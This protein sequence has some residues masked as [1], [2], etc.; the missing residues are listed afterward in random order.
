M[1]AMN[2]PFIQLLKL[3]YSQIHQVEKQE[4]QAHPFNSTVYY[5]FAPYLLYVKGYSC[6]EM[7]QCCNEANNSLKFSFGLHCKNCVQKWL[8]LSF[9]HITYLGNRKVRIN[10]AI[11]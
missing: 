5:S 1:H 2:R 9:C 8:T 3:L 11:S 10:K 7:K 4:N 6:A